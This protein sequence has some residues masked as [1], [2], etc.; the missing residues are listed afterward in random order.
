MVQ[1]GI[2]D[3]VPEVD[4]VNLEVVGAHLLNNNDPVEN[5]IS[6]YH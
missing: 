6:V 4:V 2:M 3:K 1:L 5:H